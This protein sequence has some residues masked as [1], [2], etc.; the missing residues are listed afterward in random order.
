MVGLNSRVSPVIEQ[1]ARKSEVSSPRSRG[2]R[3]GRSRS[4]TGTRRP[5]T[6]GGRVGRWP[7]RRAVLM[8][9][10]LPDPCDPHCPEVF[11]RE[12]RQILLGMHGRPKGWADALRSE[13]GL[14]RVL[15]K[16][17][18]DFANWDRAADRTWIDTGRGAG[19]RRRT[20]RSRPWSWTPSRGAARFRSKRCG[21]AARRSPAT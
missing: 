2:T 3:R 7:P 5:C 13:E 9:L 10:L 6:C 4:G 21:S 8:A 20:A 17:I 1:I 19:A 14:R 18:A 15:L 12:A 11:R 16:F